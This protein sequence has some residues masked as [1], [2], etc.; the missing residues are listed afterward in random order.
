MARNFKS[1]ISNLKSNLKPRTM[2]ELMRSQKTSLVIL[3]KGDMI[4]GTITKLTSSEILVD[5]NA[6]TEA[7]VLEKDKK[8]LNTILSSLKV[9]DKVTV[10]VLNP[11]SDFGY[12]VISLR[13]FLDNLLWDRILKYQKEREVLNASVN[14]TVRGGFLVSTSDGI[15]GFLPYSQ[16]SFAQS[17][18]KSVKTADLSPNLAGRSIKVIILE[19]D[20]TTH[21]IIFS[22]TQA[23]SSREFEAEVKNLK[24]GQK[25]QT[26]VK[27]ITP[28]GL[29]VSVS[30]KNHTIDGFIHVSEVSWDKISDISSIYRIGDSV[31]AKILDFDKDT[32][33]VNL[34]IKKLQL[35]PFKEKI[36]DLSIDKKIKAKVVEITSSGVLLSLGDNLEGIIRKEKIPPTV[37]YK[38]DDMIDAM[39]SEIDEKKRRIILVPILKEKPLTYR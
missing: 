22:Q 9:G 4:E 12:P 32:R 17:L 11:E 14:E 16:V 24:T 5:I 7:V 2:A 39:V 3:H 19:V 33:R 10:Q 26:L 28:F 29:F 37:F 15:S 18:E 36:K 30:I 23:L 13:R 8:I 20:R 27:N 35:D 21:K 34:S 25:I 31:D 1:Q 6:K 38:T